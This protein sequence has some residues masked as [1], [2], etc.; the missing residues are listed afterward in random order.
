MVLGKSIF[1]SFT[2]MTQVLLPFLARCITR[3]YRCQGKHDTDPRRWYKPHFLHPPLYTGPHLNT[4]LRQ[5]EQ[6][7]EECSTE[8]EPYFDKESEEADRNADTLRIVDRIAQHDGSGT[9]V[10]YVER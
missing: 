6:R 5:T 8:E 4:L 3:V 9:H 10:Q 1:L 2:S 7:R